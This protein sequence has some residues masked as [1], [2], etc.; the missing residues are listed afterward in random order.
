MQ[1]LLVETPTDLT[2][3]REWIRRSIDEL[4]PAIDSDPS[5]ELLANVARLIRRAKRHAYTLGL[6]ELANLLPERET[7]TPLDGLLRLRECSQWRGALPADG[8]ALTVRQAATAL[9]ISERL[10][11]DLIER[12]QLGHHRVGNGRGR[13]RIRPSD[14][15]EYQSR[16][17]R[18]VTGLRHLRG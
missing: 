11:R 2:S 4:T 12:G 13:I 8:R 3:F 16:A 18:P 15:S 10:A 5:S 9:G 17:E 6:Y 14:L 1:Q 7:K